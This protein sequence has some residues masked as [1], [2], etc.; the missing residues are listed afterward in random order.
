MNTK[1]AIKKQGKRCHDSKNEGK[2]QKT[3]TIL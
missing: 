3:V 1:L 2:Y